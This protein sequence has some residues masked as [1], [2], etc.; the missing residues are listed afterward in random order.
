MEFLKEIVSSFEKAPVIIILSSTPFRCDQ[1]IK[2]VR[3]IGELTVF[4]TLSEDEGIEKIKNTPTVDLVLISSRYTEG[5][6]KRIHSFISENKP[7]IKL[8]EPG[9]DYPY[10][11]ETILSDIREKLGI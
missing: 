9:W 11:E 6:R 4:G 1:L 2:L 10:K 7:T 5:Q 8:T 3:T